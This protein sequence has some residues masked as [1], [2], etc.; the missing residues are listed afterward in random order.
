[1]L[2][3]LSNNIKND[4]PEKME[5]EEFTDKEIDENNITENLRT[6]LMQVR[7]EIEDLK[8]LIISQSR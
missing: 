6:E 7:N 4:I 3:S 8:R 2:C 5:T 1:M